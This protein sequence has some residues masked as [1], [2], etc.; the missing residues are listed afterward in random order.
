MIDPIIMPYIIL[1]VVGKSCTDVVICIEPL[2]SISVFYNEFRGGGY[3][4]EQC[5]GVVYSLTIYY[6]IK[7]QYTPLLSRV[8][9]LLRV[10]T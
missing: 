10:D 3:R 8:E 4:H 7:G 9:G 5:S 1:G 6:V 2:S